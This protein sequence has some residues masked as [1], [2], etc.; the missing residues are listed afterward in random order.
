MKRNP[1]SFAFSSCTLA[2]LG[3]ALTSLTSSA[4]LI[5]VQFG[6]I[7]PSPVYVGQG[8]LTGGVYWNQFMGSTNNSPLLSALDLPTS[9]TLSVSS[10]ATYDQMNSHNPYPAPADVLPTEP[11]ALLENIIFTFN[12]EPI[13]LTLN[14]LSASTAYD[15]VVYNGGNSTNF[16]LNG[17]PAQTVTGT[18][19]NANATFVNGSSYTVL[20]GTSNAQGVI[21]I[22]TTSQT[23]NDISGLQIEA[24]PE[25]SSYAMLLGGLG[26]LVYASRLVRNRLA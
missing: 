1:A 23:E 18:P 5:N 19:Y 10:V 22:T 13:T 11:D 14:G 16:S 7:P 24:V 20:E 9:V 12:L 25:P 15:V 6:V 2:I 3:W 21:T 4:Q 26:L 17:G 8:V